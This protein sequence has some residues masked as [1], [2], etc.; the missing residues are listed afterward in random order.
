MTRIRSKDVPPSA[1]TRT[2]SFVRTVTSQL[3][4]AAKKS[5][6]VKPPTSIG[7][8][9]DPFCRSSSIFR[10]LSWKRSVATQ[11][12]SL[13]ELNPAWFRSTRCRPAPSVATK[14]S[15][16]TPTA[17][18]A[19]WSSLCK[20]VWIQSSFCFLEDTLSLFHKL[21]PSSNKAR[22]TRW[23]AC[24]WF[25]WSSRPQIQHKAVSSQSSSALGLSWAN[26]TSRAK[27]MSLKSNTLF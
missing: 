15:P 6:I 5:L 18:V 12:S 11:N 2:W 9:T 23:M 27:P 25:T 19:V 4:S 8:R 16:K 7:A 13:L 10:A 26:L 1:S 3:A 21:R 14:S 22:P 24:T 20:E 17:K